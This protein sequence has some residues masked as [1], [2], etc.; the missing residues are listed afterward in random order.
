MKYKGTIHILKVKLKG[1]SN[2]LEVC[3]CEDYG[4][5]RQKA[6]NWIDSGEVYMFIKS[7]KS[8]HKYRCLWRKRKSSRDNNDRVTLNQVY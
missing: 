4:A 1:S 8:T 2:L 6:E 7:K 3:Y 5:C